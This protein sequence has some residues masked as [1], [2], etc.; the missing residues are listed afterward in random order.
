MQRFRRRP[1]RARARTAPS[2]PVRGCRSPLPRRRPATPGASPAAAPAPDRRESHPAAATRSQRRSPPR[3]PSNANHARRHG[4]AFASR[5]GDGSRPWCGA[6]VTGCVRAPS[7]PARIVLAANPGDH[8]LPCLVRSCF[9]GAYGAGEPPPGGGGCAGARQPKR[10]AARRGWRVGIVAHRQSRDLEPEALVDTRVPGP[11]RIS[12][13]E[14][15]VAGD[16]LL[17]TVGLEARPCPIRSRT[18]APPGGR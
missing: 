11:E 6:A 16:V 13:G 5:C 15:P 1:E 17:H 8:R 7:P 10:T 3:R 18:S 12:R 14:A 4:E 2:T 9:A